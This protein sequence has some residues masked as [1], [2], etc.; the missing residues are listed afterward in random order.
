MIKQQIS[1][2]RVKSLI[3][4]RT[5]DNL[6]ATCEKIIQSEINYQN[7]FKLVISLK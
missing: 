7:L 6:K 3:L 2:L 1:T 5:F 4:K